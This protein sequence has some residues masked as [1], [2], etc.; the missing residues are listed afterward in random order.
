MVLMGVL[1]GGVLNACTSICLLFAGESVQ[2]LVEWLSGSLAFA[3]WAKVRLFAIAALVSLSLLA[4]AIPRANLIQLGDD[5]SSGLG[6]AADRTRIVV[7]FTA[8]SLTAAAVCIVGGIGFVGLVAPHLVRR[9]V[10]ADLRRLVPASALAGACLVLLA[11][12][13]ARN[14]LPGPFGL[15]FGL[16][17][18][19]ITLPVGVFLALLGG[20]F[21]LV[22]LR[23]AR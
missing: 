22:L 7:L 1:V 19:A 13:M 18:N 3:T 5:V 12:L 16:T 17:F 4:F 9:V 20:P 11:D 14:F 10:G 6:Q 23:R 8:A 21:F 15:Q 2:V